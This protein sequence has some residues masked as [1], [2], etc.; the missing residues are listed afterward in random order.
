MKGLQWAARLTIATIRGIGDPQFDL[1]WDCAAL[2]AWKAKWTGEQ[3]WAAAAYGE[4]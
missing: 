4:H 1:T 3:Q 2:D